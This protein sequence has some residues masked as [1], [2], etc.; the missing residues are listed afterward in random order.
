MSGSRVLV[1]LYNDR[2]GG[3]VDVN[4]SRCGALG[5]GRAEEIE[6]PVGEFGQDRPDPARRLALP[7]IDRLQPIGQVRDDTC[8]GRVR[9]SVDSR[10][11]PHLDEEVIHQR[12]ALRIQS[13]LPCHT[14]NGISSRVHLAEALDPPLQLDCLPLCQTSIVLGLL[15][16]NASLCGV[17]E[18]RLALA[19]LHKHRGTEAEQTREQDATDLHQD[20]DPQRQTPW[21]DHDHV[22]SSHGRRLYAS[23]HGASREAPRR[24]ALAGAPLH[25]ESGE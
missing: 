8:C 4:R 1:R 5:V 12:P 3:G 6:D 22:K 16:L 15:V 17:L 14:T 23:T 25:E 13:G 9:G 10:V 2:I 19:T 20:L 7:P 21:L 24:K 11:H 18:V